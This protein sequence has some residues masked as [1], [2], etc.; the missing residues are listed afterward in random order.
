MKSFS[1]YSEGYTAAAAKGM[2]TQ[3]LGT[4][5]TYLKFG[6]GSKHIEQGDKH[7]KQGQDVIGSELGKRARAG[8]EA[9]K[10]YLNNRMSNQMDK[11]GNKTPLKS[12]PIKK[13]RIS[14]IINALK[15][16]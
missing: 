3:E 16:R 14:K 7:F 13:S 1:Q 10:R 15:G 8:E 11:Y 9:A 4:L 2:S 6:S 5:Y 12:T